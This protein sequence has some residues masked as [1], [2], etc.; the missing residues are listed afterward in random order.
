MPERWD[1][2]AEL[3]KEQIESGLDLTFSNV[4][5]PYYQD[6]VKDY[7]L[8]SVLEIGC[9]TGHLSLELSKLVAKVVAIE[10]SMGMY[11]VAR[12]VLKE[13]GVELINKQIQDIKFEQTF[14][15]II[16]HMCIQ[17][18]EN[19]NDIFGSVRTFMNSG[20][21]FVF[22]IPHPCF[23]NDYKK[24]FSSN[25]YSYIIPIKKNITFAVTKDPDRP[26]SGVPYNHRPLSIYFNVLKKQNMFVYDFHE[27][28]PEPKVQ[29]LYGDNWKTPRYCVL[30]VKC[31]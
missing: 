19:V 27:I 1:N 13:S 5:L 8:S 4:F 31:H 20:S 11:A 6:L 28:V 12:E 29:N 24:L 30:H 15:L 3:R 23:Y 22:T 7:R 26:I 21:F 14:D 25:E 10:P 16:S 17:T 2:A 18:A 9:G